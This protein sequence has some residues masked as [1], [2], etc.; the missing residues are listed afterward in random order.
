MEKQQTSDVNNLISKKLLC[1]KQTPK[2]INGGII[3]E[4]LERPTIKT[5]SDGQQTQNMSHRHIRQHLM[6]LLELDM[7]HIVGSYE[8]GRLY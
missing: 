6:H 7:T 2:G 1:L 5:A 8:V 4:L 3:R